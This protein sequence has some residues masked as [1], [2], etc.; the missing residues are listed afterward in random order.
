MKHAKEKSTPEIAGLAQRPLY[1]PPS[2]TW[3]MTKTGFIA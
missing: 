1:F 3:D 2:P